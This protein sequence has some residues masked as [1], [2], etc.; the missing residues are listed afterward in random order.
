MSSGTNDTDLRSKY[1]R[2]SVWAERL[3][4]L[5]LVGLAVEI[6]A[7]FI[8]Q[9]PLLEGALTIAA[10]VL[11]LAGVWG[12]LLFERRAKEAGDSL[13]AVANARAAE[14]NTRAEEARLELAR[15]T[16]PRSLTAEQ[17]SE[18]TERARPFAGTPFVLFIQPQ[19]EPLNLANQI[20]DA[21]TTAGWVW[22]PAGTTVTLNRPN[23]PSVGMATAIGV[24][25]QMTS[26]KRAEWEAAVLAVANALHSAGIET[27]AEDIADDSISNTAVHIRVDAKL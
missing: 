11:I 19:P 8:L 22:Q 17:Q 13:V 12:E 25:V 16:T 3:A 6:A 15:L 4:V 10:S 1:E 5:I 9:K 18:L 26:S 14:A 27:K 21:L 20:A 7:V 24:A 23:K 2:N